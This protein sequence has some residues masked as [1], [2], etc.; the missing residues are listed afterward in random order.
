MNEQDS[1]PPYLPSHIANYFLW[2]AKQ[3][4]V[5]DLTTMKLIKLVYFSYAWYYALFGKKLFSEKIEAWRYGP[6]IPSIYHEFKRAANDPIDFFSMNFAMKTGE[7]SYPIIKN[8]DDDIIQLLSAVWAV[9]KDKS[10]LELS[11]I[12]HE[13]GSPWCHAYDQGENSPMDDSLIRE[14][15]KQAIVKYKGKW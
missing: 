12:T 14:R 6:V 1:E 3:E 8:G 13:D 11:D 5:E 10:G 15:A 9:Y 7:I 4:N 2:L